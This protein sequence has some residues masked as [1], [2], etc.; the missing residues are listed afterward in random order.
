MKNNE[1]RRNREKNE[2]KF[3]IS[4]SNH[5]IRFFKYSQIYSAFTIFVTFK[6]FVVR[7]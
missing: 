6:N 5:E 3:D 4:I 2:E 1:N 7:P